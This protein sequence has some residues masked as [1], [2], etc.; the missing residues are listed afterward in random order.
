MA[1]LFN[2]PFGGGQE[3]VKLG[4]SRITP[5]ETYSSNPAAIQGQYRDQLARTNQLV[6][7][8]SSFG[9]TLGAVEA[10]K[11]EEELKQTDLIAAQIVGQLNGDS[12]IQDQIATLRP[13]LNPLLRAAVSEAIGRQ[14]GELEAQRFVES[15]SPDISNDPVKTT[16]AFQQRLAEEASRVQ[17]QNFYGP[18]YVG[19]MKKAFDRRSGQLSAERTQQMRTILLT[20]H[21]KTLYD[22]GRSA[23]TNT[24]TNRPSPVGDVTPEEM[25]QLR[26]KVSYDLGGKKRSERP[27]ESVVLRAAKAVTSV[28]PNWKIVV[29]SGGGEFGSD[30][31]RAKN[32][33]KAAD[34]YI[35]DEN[36]KKINYREHRSEVN[37][38]FQNLASVGLKGLGFYGDN[39]SIH[40]DDVR[41]SQWGPTKSSASL[42]P[43]LAASINRGRQIFSGGG[44]QT[45]SPFKPM[46][47]QEYFGEESGSLPAGMRNNNI[48]NIKHSSW[49]RRLPG[50]VGPSRN[51]DQGD[52]QV[53]FDSPEAGVAGAARLALNKYQGG[54]TTPRQLIADSKKGWTPGFTGA[55]E[56]IAK[57]MGIGVDEDM[58]LKDPVRMQ[59]FIKALAKQEHG[60]AASKFKD[61]TIE[62]GVNAV[63]GGSVQPTSSGAPAPTSTPPATN[64]L[65]GTPSVSQPNPAAFD[66]PAPGQS[67]APLREDVAR[68]RTYFV[69]QDERARRISGGLI[70][71]AEFKE[72]MIE[73]T[74]RL[75][76][77][78]NNGFGDVE[79]LRA[80]PP[81]ILDP[82]D[83][84][85][86]QEAQKAILSH[87]REQ[88]NF[89]HTQRERARVEAKRNAESYLNGI[90]MRREELPT[91]KRMEINGLFPELIKE[92]DDRRRAIDNGMINPRESAESAGRLKSEMTAAFLSG[93]DP[94]TFRER[95]RGALKYLNE[96]DFD[97][98]LKHADNLRTSEKELFNQ[99]YDNMT[100]TFLVTNYGVT[101]ESLVTPNP[102]QNPLNRDAGKALDILRNNL[103]NEIATFATQNKR[104]PSTMQDRI[105]LF[106]RA[107]DLTLRMIPATDPRVS[108]KTG[109]EDSKAKSFNEIFGAP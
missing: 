59:A 32:G 37:Q 94:D 99:V 25:E 39:P 75:A 33:Y 52:P 97:A 90:L 4:S 28:N 83:R 96:N 8:M 35:V 40:V 21:D 48:G 24:P 63:L 22:G 54:L 84:K 67:E 23:L 17:G 74:I 78:A 100:K 103:L 27:E 93:T 49:S 82:A 13:D 2:D 81:N 43:D 26:P 57:I 104:P 45:K 72:R 18:Q 64:I 47:P 89:A 69:Q 10:K 71:K 87:Q 58:N 60:A 85:K 88:I 16:T 95:N 79:V 36:G 42:P 61:E 91:D 7:A 77:D 66:P 73:Q 65:T 31:H 101:A 76:R 5:R 68:L 62:A 9:R 41:I 86:L 1:I 20:D 11:R 108:G 105:A 15:L 106:E 98:V 51:T 38:I 102:A 29:H 70:A 12:A 6:D 55:A 56:N 46:S 92:L 34:I 19:A 44:E 80:V 107:R 3:E 14:H 50:A 109:N 53:V 30:R